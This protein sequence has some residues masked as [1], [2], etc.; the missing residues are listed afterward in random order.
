[1]RRYSYVGPD[2]IRLGVDTSRRGTAIREGTDL[3]SFANGEPS[4]FVIDTSGMMR[5]A[6]RRSE[7]VACAGGDE[8]LSAG[9]VTVV[10]EARGYR[11]IEISNQSTGY[12]P[13]PESWPVVARALDA[14]GIPHPGC[15]TY[16][17]IFRRCDEC[18]ERNLV[19][20]SWFFCAVCGAKLS[21][22]WNF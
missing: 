18:G 17:V 22:S 16:E 7:H 11:V 8:V 1:M 5:V 14:A 12:C 19:K 2:E 4:T 20:D 6:D 13:E 15:F 10:R 9:E 21:S 3:K